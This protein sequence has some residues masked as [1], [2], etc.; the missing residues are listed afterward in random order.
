MLLYILKSSQGYLEVMTG[1]KCVW[2]G[3]LLGYIN[4]YVDYT[5]ILSGFMC[6]NNCYSVSRTRFRGIWW[7]GFI[8]LV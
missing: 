4:V 8:V 6:Y 3:N 5:N 7:W 2:C 1:N